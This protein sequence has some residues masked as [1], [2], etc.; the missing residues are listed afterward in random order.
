MEGLVGDRPSC[1][2]VCG[3]P[4]SVPGYFV[5]LSIFKHFAEW[6]KNELQSGLHLGVTKKDGERESKEGDRGSS[7]RE[8]C[9]QAA[10]L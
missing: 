9:W 1:W 3:V 10:F 2:G 4:N 8:T 5:E 6:N 7:L